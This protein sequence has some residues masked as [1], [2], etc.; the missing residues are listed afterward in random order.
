MR[1]K[2]ELKRNFY[3]ITKAPD[4][5]YE[6]KPTQPLGFVASGGGMKGIG[7]AGIIKAF[8]ERDLIKGFTHVSGASAGAMTASL[9]AVGME[10]TNIE[11]LVSN[12]DLLNLF[13]N[14]GW[15]RFRAKGNVFRNI[16][17][18]IYMQQIAGYFQTIQQPEEEPLRSYYSLIEQKIKLHHRFLK[19]AGI[20]IT[21]I[22]D[23]IQLTADPEK[24]KQ[25][26][27]KF[28]KH[29][30]RKWRISGTEVRVN[31]KITF[32]DLEN[33]RELLPPDQKHLIKHLSVVTTN[34]TQKVLET[35]NAIN[36]PEDSISTK[37]QLSSAHPLLFSPG[38]NELGES[39]ADGGI[40]NNMP[41][42][43]LEEQFGLSPE[44][45]LCAKIEAQETFEDRL[46]NALS[47]ALVILSSFDR[48]L[49]S[50]AGFFLGGGLFGGR[51][52]VLNN[53]KVYHFVNNMIYINSGEVT[54]TTTSISA[55]QKKE[56]IESS[57]HQTNTLLDAQVKRF[58]H[59]LLA[60]LY[61]GK[62]YLETTL[63]NTDDPL[64]LLSTA[65]AQKIFLLQQQIVNEIK[66][67]IFSNVINLVE[68]IADVFDK[69][70]A[71]H[72]EQLGHEILMT[73]EQGEQALSLCLKQINYNTH[74]Q[75]ENYLLKEIEAEDDSDR[76]SILARLLDLLHRSIEWIFAQISR[77]FTSLTSPNDDPVDSTPEATGSQKVDEEEPNMASE[78][79]TASRT[80]LPRTMYNLFK[81]PEVNSKK[82]EAPLSE[83]NAQQDTE[84]SNDSTGKKSSLS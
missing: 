4:G 3:E 58:N 65:Q 30:N 35:W 17:D 47:H 15:L 40:L 36:S 78:E 71:F 45:I 60:R 21:S 56:L 53:E 84:V 31:P 48:L 28:N 82:I 26:N 13:D 61:L 55:E 19:A 79:K 80:I 37:V 69:D 9:L 59:P 20:S 8:H 64:V 12:L 50:I 63:N 75:L 66:L 44:Q 22:E 7:Y 68:Q 39:I 83:E 72:A 46:K 18:V 81:M 23:I 6:I 1:E 14:D 41:S 38:V 70:V 73:E 32:G 5:M 10:H 16:L 27:N 24:L 33:L 11:K 76:V 57:Y 62:K 29:L 49:D 77:P 74:G 67:N 52:E 34:Q 42:E 54:T 25:L 2:R 43:V 51:A